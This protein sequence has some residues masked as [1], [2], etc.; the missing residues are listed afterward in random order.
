MLLLVSG[1]PGTGKSAVAARL[2][3]DMQGVHLSVDEVED[4]MLGAG[5]PRDRTTG[6]AAYEAVRAA[7]EQN[8][9]LGHSVVVDAVNDNAAARS[10]WHSAAERT[11][12]LLR[13]VHLTPPPPQEHQRRL[14]TRRRGLVHV[15]EP[16]W[17]QVEAR[18]LIYEA[19]GD[20]CLS[21]DSGQPLEAVVGE[22]HR[23][24]NG[25]T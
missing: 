20:E 1:L 12:V 23:R 5:L 7:A 24:L 25:A 9:A 16:T 6:V 11:H 13:F 4:A 19:W 18:A 17:E 2:A 8:L 10:T 22:I 3:L 15:P 14:T 21:V